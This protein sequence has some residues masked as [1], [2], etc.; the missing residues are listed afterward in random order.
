MTTMPHM[1]PATTRKRGLEAA[2]QNHLEQN[3]GRQIDQ[4]FDFDPV[5]MRLIRADLRKKKMT[6]KKTTTPNVRYGWDLPVRRT[7]KSRLQISREPHVREGLTMMTTTT[8][9]VSEMTRAMT[10]RR[11]AGSIVE[12]FGA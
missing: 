4:E 11:E 1:A 3:Q 8:K 6:K 5:A 10:W 9:A 2:G 7:R 12:V